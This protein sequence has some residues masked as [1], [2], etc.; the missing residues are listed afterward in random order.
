MINNDMWNKTVRKTGSP[1]AVLAMTLL[2]SG[3]Y[4]G[5]PSESPPIH[6]NPNM[7]SQPRY[8]A[9]G[10]SAFFL[11][12]SSMR[13]PVAGTVARGE[14]FEDAGLNTGMDAQGDTLRKIPFPVTMSFMK[15]GKERFNIY[16]LPCH[17]GLGEGNGMVV[18]RG[19]IPPPTWHSEL[20]RNYPDGHIFNVISNG[21][22]NM[23]AYRHQV[24]VKDRWAIVAYFRALLRSQNSTRADLP[25]D[26]KAELSK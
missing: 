15:R 21:I 3:C 10:E 20:V 16:C 4:Q 18:K 9:Q 1:I 7:D 26:K 12:N 22:R 5:R 2:L 17:G 19:L 6:I 11:D 13:P 14:L 24:S 8:K 25:D 23:P